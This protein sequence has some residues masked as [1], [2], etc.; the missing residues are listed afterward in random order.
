MSFRHQVPGAAPLSTVAESE[1][2]LGLV[3]APSNRSAISSD[4]LLS[5]DRA[6]HL[7]GSGASGQRSR[8][9]REGPPLDTLCHGNADLDPGEATE[10]SA[11]HH[12]KRK[13]KEGKDRKG[14]GGKD[15]FVEMDRGGPSQRPLGRIA[16]RRAA[17]HHGKALRT[18]NSDHSFKQAVAE[19]VGTAGTGWWCAMW[20]WA[21]PWEGGR[22]AWVGG[23]DAPG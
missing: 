15:S 14:G 21:V 12:G 18:L 6:R 23:R 10:D 4:S 16:Q 9:A 19:W 20:A 8:L 3:E 7:A 17:R 1:H 22:G 5:R 11:L 2:C 13:K